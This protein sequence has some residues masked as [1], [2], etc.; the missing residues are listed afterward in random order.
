MIE[1]C[2]IVG[3]SDKKIKDPEYHKTIEMQTLLDRSKI[4]RII[5][6]GKKLEK[7]YKKH[8]G[9]INM[10]YFAVLSTSAAN[11]GRSFQRIENWREELP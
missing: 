9:E 11:N 6:N 3:S 1:S 2:E 5:L 8:F 4:K 7:V 10:P